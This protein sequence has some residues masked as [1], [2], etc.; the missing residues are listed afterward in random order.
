LK[1]DAV[2]RTKCFDGE[3]TFALLIKDVQPFGFASALVF[4]KD[5]Y[6]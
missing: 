1:M 5:L 4:H 6:L 2:S 3:S